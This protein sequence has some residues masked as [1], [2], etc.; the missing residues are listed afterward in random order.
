VLVARA[1]HATGP[2]VRLGEA[3]GTNSSAI[4]EKDD[5]WLAPGHNSIFTDDQG[6]EWIAY[7]A[8]H[9]QAK[10]PRVMCISRIT[11][12]DGWPQVSR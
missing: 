5:R 12:K 2:F 11:Y 9:P 1:D 10:G 6:N 7:H 3:N 4:L 8:M